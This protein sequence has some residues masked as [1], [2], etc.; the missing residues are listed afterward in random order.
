MKLSRRR[1]ARLRLWRRRLHAFNI[2]FLRLFIRLI[3]SENQRVFGLT[4]VIG[5]VCGLAAVAFHL[6]I[7]FAEATLI[8][9]ALNAS[10]YSWIW[11]TILVPIAGGLLCGWLLQN[12]VPDARGSGIPQVKVAYTVKGGR[13]P[14]RDRNREIFYRCDSDR[15]GRVFGARRSDGSDL[16]R[17]C[18]A[19]RTFCRAVAAEYG[20]TFA[21]R[22]GSGN[23]GGV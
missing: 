13:M 15:F 21:G 12:V 8:E 20:E 11:L 23:C 18:R 9:R 6:A 19:S 22:R 2:E 16:R 14:F 17:N 10:G 3:P 7:R 1:K 5:V 4:L